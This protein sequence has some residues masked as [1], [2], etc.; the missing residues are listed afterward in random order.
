M[1]KLCR[2]CG[3]KIAKGKRTRGTSAG[4]NLNETFSINV[5]LDVPHTHR[6]PHTAPRHFCH[7]CKNAIYNKRKKQ[8]RKVISPRLILMYAYI[9]GKISV[10]VCKVFGPPPHTVWQTYKNNGS[11]QFRVQLECWSLRFLLS[12]MWLSWIYTPLPGGR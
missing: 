6:S 10:A 11:P 12:V 9:P 1:G 5:S 3:S 8:Q 7:S 2:V 4:S